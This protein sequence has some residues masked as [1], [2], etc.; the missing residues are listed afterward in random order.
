MIAR[1]HFKGI[2]NWIGVG[3]TRGFVAMPKARKHNI[4][5]LDSWVKPPDFDL[6]YEFTQHESTSLEELPERIKDATII[7]ISG[8][9]INRAGIE[10]APNLELIACNGVG[11]DHIDKETA[12]QRG[13]SVCRV[14]AQNTESVSEHALALYYSIRR[15][16]VEMH[17]IAMDGKTWPSHNMIA[18][19]LG[20]PPRTNGEERVVVIGYGAL[21]MFSTWMVIDL[22]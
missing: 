17:S 2:R 21:G 13:V 15:R 9:K 22:Y 11:T 4:V 19:K 12:Q 5:A 20:Q 10:N 18:K 6:S 7:I 1:V 3:R 8:T 16:V 14:P